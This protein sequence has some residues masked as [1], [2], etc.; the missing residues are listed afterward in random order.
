MIGN[1]LASRAHISSREKIQSPGGSPWFSTKAALASSIRLE[2][3]TP[4]GHSDLQSLQ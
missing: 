3:S 1:R 2:T 4:A